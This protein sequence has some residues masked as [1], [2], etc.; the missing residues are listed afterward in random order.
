MTKAEFLELRAGEQ[1]WVLFRC[2]RLV[3]CTLV[4]FLTVGTAQEKQHRG[5]LAYD[6]LNEEADEA[7]WEKTEIES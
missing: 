3:C 4:A 1:R 6:E 7:A 2:L 5:R